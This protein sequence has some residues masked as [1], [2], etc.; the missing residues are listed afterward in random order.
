MPQFSRLDKPDSYYEKL[1][2]RKHPD[3]WPDCS[4]RQ[5]WSNP[6]CCIPCRYEFRDITSLRKHANATH[7]GKLTK[8]DIRAYQAKNVLVP[9]GLG[10]LQRTLASETTAHSFDLRSI[11]R[12]AE[13][14]ALRKYG[15]KRKPSFR[16]HDRHVLRDI[17]E[18]GQ[19]KNITAPC[20]AEQALA[21]YRI[22]VAAGVSPQFV[23]SAL[24]S[25]GLELLSLELR[26][27]PTAPAV[28]IP[29]S[30]VR[31]KETEFPYELRKHD[32][33]KPE[34]ENKRLF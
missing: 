8:R 10:Y 27:H 12:F 11:S 34:T 21:V 32:I 28:P 5:C 30:P 18:Q 9:D 24:I 25:Y 13:S 17:E 33:R 2:S 31:K 1:A 6:I 14:L 26:K 20:T 23:A 7:S 15:V 29:K 16:R 19:P 4:C 3:H 22:A